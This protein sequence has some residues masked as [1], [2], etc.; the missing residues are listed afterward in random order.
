MYSKVCNFCKAYATLPLPL[1]SMFLPKR[2]RKKNLAFLAGHS[3]RG[4]TFLASLTNGKL[5]HIYSGGYK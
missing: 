3:A 4:G 1:S 5:F 2:A